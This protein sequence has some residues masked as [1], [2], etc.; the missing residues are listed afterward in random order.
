MVGGSISFSS[1]KTSQSFTSNEQTIKYSN[2]AIIPSY[3]KAIKTNLLVGADLNYS[4]SVNETI[5]S[6]NIGS[7]RITNKGFG[8]GV[9]S[10]HYKNFGTSGFYLFLQNRLGVDINKNKYNEF[11]TNGFNLTLGLTPGIAYAIDQKVH[12]ETALN[13]LF[14]VAYF[15]NSSKSEL[16]QPGSTKNSGFGASL[17]L[18]SSTQFVVGVK[19]LFGS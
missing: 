5:N 14:S 10:R 17:G 19:F 16:N 2:I 7:S 1:Q 8:V 11:N 15:H 12:I 18:G 6:N 3:A 9:F 13:N 4:H